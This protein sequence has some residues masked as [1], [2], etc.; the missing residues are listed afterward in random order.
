MFRRILLRFIA[1]KMSSHQMS[2]NKSRSSKCRHFCFVFDT[3][4]YCPTCRE[5]AKGDDPCVT[6]EKPCNICSAFTEEQLI[7]SNG[8]IRWILWLSVHYAAAVRRE[9]FGI[10]ALRG[11]LHQLGLPNLQ[12]IFGGGGGGGVSFWDGN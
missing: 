3:Y 11:K 4:N 12:D 9:I 1:V 6:N 8:G 5:A 7:V 2:S 10:N